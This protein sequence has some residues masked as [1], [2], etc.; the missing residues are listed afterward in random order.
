[1]NIITKYRILHYFHKNNIIDETSAIR[2]DSI[3]VDVLVKDEW[4]IKH[5]DSYYLNILVYQWRMKYRYIQLIGILLLIILFFLYA[6]KN[7]VFFRY[8]Y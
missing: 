8:R 7:Y 5:N 4:L 3:N 6:F 2:M 1:M